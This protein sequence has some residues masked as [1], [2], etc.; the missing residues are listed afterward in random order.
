MSAGLALM[1]EIAVDGPIAAAFNSNVAGTAGATLPQGQVYA[2]QSYVPQGY[3]APQTYQAPG[4]YLSHGLPLPD[5]LL[6]HVLEHGAVRRGRV[7]ARK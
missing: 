4:G 6:E 1:P 5:G 2:G 3:Q 7:P